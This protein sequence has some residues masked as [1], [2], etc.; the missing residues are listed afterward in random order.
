MQR[1][2]REDTDNTSDV[3]DDLGLEPQYCVSKR[4]DHNKGNVMERYV[5]A[6]ESL[7]KQID[8]FML[9]GISEMYHFEPCLVAR[10]VN[11]AVLE[12]LPS[13]IGE[14]Y[15]KCVVDSGNLLITDLGP[16]GAHGAGVAEIVGQA[17]EW[18]KLVFDI[19]TNVVI[20]TDN[21]RSGFAPDLVI[22]VRAGQR[23]AGLSHAHLGKPRLVRYHDW[24]CGLLMV[25]FL[26]SDH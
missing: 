14:K 3:I 15:V 25:V 9:T 17:R 24:P 20:K 13:L 23:Q 19:R 10:D 12:E 16:G 8:D 21:N 22:Q 6:V 1:R 26:C 7:S 11:A 2:D 4:C 5:N 18:S